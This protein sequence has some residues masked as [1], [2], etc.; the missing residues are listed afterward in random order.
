MSLPHTTIATTCPEHIP[1]QGL[2]Q[3]QKPYCHVTMR[4]AVTTARHGK[5]HDNT[6][7]NVRGNPSGRA[8]GN[9]HGE[10]HDTAPHGKSGPRRNPRRILRQGPTTRPA[11]RCHCITRCKSRRHYHG[12]PRKRTAATPASNVTDKGVSAGRPTT[13][14]E[15]RIR[16]CTCGR[17]KG[18]K[19]DGH[20][21][22]DEV[23][24]MSIMP[25]EVLHWIL[26]RV[27]SW[28]LPR[29]LPCP[30]PWVILPDFLR[31]VLW[32]WTQASPRVSSRGLVASR[33]AALTAGRTV[34]CCRRSWRG[35][36][37]GVCPRG[38]CGGSCRGI[39][40]GCCRDARRGT[41]WKASRQ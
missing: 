21:A 24:N 2:Q 17:E 40:R 20:T 37:R 30:L 32:V 3:A 7:G 12:M 39:Y 33:V 9:T 27:G 38:S 11:V 29:E 16:L 19:W 15:G 22:G 10:Y 31:V 14:A 8:H 28:V 6:Q 36:W 25:G 13:R 23:L 18:A 26:P 35:F 1:H 5:T 34:A 4:L 41:P